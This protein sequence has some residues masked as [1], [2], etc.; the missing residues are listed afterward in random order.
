MEQQKPECKNMDA[1]LRRL[2]QEL[3]CCV[4]VLATCTVAALNGVGL[5]VQKIELISNIYVPNI[6]NKIRCFFACFVSG[7]ILVFSLS[8]GLMCIL[9]YLFYY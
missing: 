2:K 7:Q 4:C 3:V 8:W 5:L 6:Q 9:I 1:C